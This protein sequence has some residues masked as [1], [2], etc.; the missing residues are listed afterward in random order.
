[1]VQRRQRDDILRHHQQ[2]RPRPIGQRRPAHLLLVPRLL[3]VGVRHVLL[4]DRAA[5]QSHRRADLAVHVVL[6]RPPS[7]PL[8]VA[9]RAGEDHP[10]AQLGQDG[11]IASRLDLVVHEDAAIAEDRI[12]AGM[13]ERRIPC[14]RADA[15]DSHARG[16]LGHAHT[17]EALDASLQSIEA[18]AMPL[19][20][21]ALVVVRRRPEGLQHGPVD[22][23][24]RAGH[25]RL[26]TIA[27]RGD[28]PC[29]TVERDRKALARHPHQPV[30]LR[31]LERRDLVQ[32]HHRSRRHV[33]RDPE[34]LPRHLVT[35]LRPAPVLAQMEAHPEPVLRA[36]RQ[37]RL[38]DRNT[39]HRLLAGREL[40]GLEF[41]ALHDR[42]VLG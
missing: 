14:A 4:G 31:N 32:A 29:L 41:A 19:P 42:A 38:L 9:E 3:G 11:Q 10:D 40:E 5:V 6:V 35:L 27:E 22:G 36:R 30:R 21:E 17:A 39:Q 8:Q 2:P 24:V 28:R 25:D 23:L 12:R 33:V 16:R 20:G 1:M 18:R 34:L 7:I 26:A 13:N 37:R 15:P